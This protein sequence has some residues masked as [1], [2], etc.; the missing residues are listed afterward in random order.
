[1]KLEM[2]LHF[3]LSQSTHKTKGILTMVFYTSG[4]NLVILAGM[5]D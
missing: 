2:Y 4:P 1:M 5:S 3:P